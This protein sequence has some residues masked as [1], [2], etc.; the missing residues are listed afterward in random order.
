MQKR[1]E[2][3][4]GSVGLE[5]RVHQLRNGICH[6]DQVL[7]SCADVVFNSFFLV[8]IMT[9]LSTRVKTFVSHWWGE[10]FSSWVSGPGVELRN[11]VC[12]VPHRRL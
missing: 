4:V 6:L 7:C 2:R 12:R 10:E 3:S 9:S 8:S 1:G 11:S 5:R